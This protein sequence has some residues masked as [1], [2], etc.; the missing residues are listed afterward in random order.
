MSLQLSE[1]KWPKIG[2]GSYPSWSFVQ[3]SYLILGTPEPSLYTIKAILIL[4]NDGERIVAKY[5]DDSGNFHRHFHLFLTSGSA[6]DYS[7][8][9]DSI[10]SEPIVQRKIDFENSIKFLVESKNKKPSRKLF[11][12]KLQ[13]A[14]PKFYFWTV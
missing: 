3:N 5:Y 13:K 14:T 7:P 10:G 11:S 1:G 9:S 4:D 8:Y 6:L 2:C 12:I